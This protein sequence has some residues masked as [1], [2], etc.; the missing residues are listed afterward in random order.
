MCVCVCVCV[1]AFVYVLSMSVVCVDP[2]KQIYDNIRY[3]V[4]RG[5]L[6]HWGNSG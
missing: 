5:N 6:A 3:R 2:Y 1:R 4:K